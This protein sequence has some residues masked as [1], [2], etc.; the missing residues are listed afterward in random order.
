MAGLAALVVTACAAVDARDP[1]WQ[2][3]KVAVSLKL[4]QTWT[5]Q[6]EPVAAPSPTSSTEAEQTPPT[7]GL[8]RAEL[9]AKWNALAGDAYELDARDRFVDPEQRRVRCSPEELVL[10]RGTA[11][12]YHA[13]LTV[14]PPFQER[15][16]QF[17]TVVA[18]VAREVYG[19]APRR[20]QHYGAYSCR[21][22]RQRSHRLSE[23]ALGNAVDVVGFDFGPA[24]KLEPLAPELPRSLKGPFQVRVS[25]HWMATGN[26][27]SETHARFLRLMTDRLIER[28]DI[29]RGFVGPGHRGHADHFHFDM[30]PWRYVRL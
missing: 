21:T 16:A 28:R 8:S 5:P 19:R 7:W 29:F 14:T 4:P 10:Y 9:W 15:L 11:L 25:K 17:E 1:S 12:R 23:H 20:I 24:T 27:T 3:P 6:P 13:P 18:E 26:T 30:S 2:K 22:S